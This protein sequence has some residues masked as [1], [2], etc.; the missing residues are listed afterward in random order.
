MMGVGLCYRD[1][2]YLF[3]LNKKEAITIV[4]LSTRS[5]SEMLDEG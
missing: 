3:G 4:S 1:F 2:G 5:K